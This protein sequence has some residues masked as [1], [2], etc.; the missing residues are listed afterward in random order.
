MPTT[1]RYADVHA[2]ADAAVIRRVLAIESARFR[3]TD[4]PWL[5]EEET[6]A[7]LGAPDCG[8]WTGLRDHAMISTLIATGLRISELLALTRSDARV[9]PTGSH[10]RCPAKRRRERS[11]PLDPAAAAVMNPCL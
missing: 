8:T 3:S 10:V 7:L 11:T 2:P 6:D 9:Q 5:E 1:S 4:T